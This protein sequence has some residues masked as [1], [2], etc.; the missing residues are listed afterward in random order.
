MAQVPSDRS[1]RIIDLLAL[2]KFF[3]LGVAEPVF[4]LQ[5]IAGRRGRVRLESERSPRAGTFRMMDAHDRQSRQEVAHEDPGISHVDRGLAEDS[6]EHQRSIA[7]DR[8]HHDVAI[9]SVSIMEH[10]QLSQAHPSRGESLAEHG[11]QD[12][13]YVGIR[14]RQEWEAGLV[15]TVRP[16][17]DP[18]SSEGS[19]RQDESTGPMPDTL[20][21]SHIQTLDLHAIDVFLETQDESIGDIGKAR[22]GAKPIDGHPGSIDALVGIRVEVHIERPIGLSLASVGSDQRQGRAAHT[23]PGPV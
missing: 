23:Y 9:C 4:D 2:S 19:C 12:A 6:K 20:I 5:A 8:R 21:C 17:D 16:K 22:V 13:W 10:R 18:R 11:R 15:L 3:R 1:A 7:I 14:V